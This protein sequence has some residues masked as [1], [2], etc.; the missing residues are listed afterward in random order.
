M[1]MEGQ[2]DRQEGQRHTVTH[3]RLQ[4]T[5]LLSATFEMIMKTF[6]NLAKISTRKLTRKNC[7]APWRPRK[8]TPTGRHFHTDWT[9]NVTSRELTWFYYSQITKHEPP[10]GGHNKYFKKFHEDWTKNLTSRVLNRKNTPHPG[11]HIF[12][13]TI[14]K[15]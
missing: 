13:P 3:L 9:I 8:A 11:G 4:G 5:E 7:T 12:Q 14:T 2:A 10:P 1:L 15:F 6:S